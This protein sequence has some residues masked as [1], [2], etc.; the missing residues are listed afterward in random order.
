MLRLLDDTGGYEQVHIQTYCDWYGPGYKI[1][2]DAKEHGNVV[3]V[4]PET[5]QVLLGALVV[6]SCAS[7]RIAYNQT[8]ADMLL[9]DGYSQYAMTHQRCPMPEGTPI[10]SVLMA[11]KVMREIGITYA[12][13]RPWL[14]VSLA[15]LGTVVLIGCIAARCLDRLREQRTEKPSQC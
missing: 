6:G 15:T 3:T 13:P 10:M 5:T 8:A 4:T 11:A 1:I 14:I 7:S 2:I 9:L 12:P